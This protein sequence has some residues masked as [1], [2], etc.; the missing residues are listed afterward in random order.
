MKKSGFTLIEVLATLAVSMIA[1]IATVQFGQRWWQQQQE[2]QFFADFQRDWAHL[3][4]MAIT[5]HVTVEVWWNRDQQSFR[6][7]Q[8]KRL[9]KLYLPRPKSLTT[10]FP[11]GNNNWSLMYSGDNFA[12]PQTL[13]FHS[14]HSTDKVQFTWQLG[15]GVLLRKIVDQG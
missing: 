15:T 12:K 13:I 2:A 3:R 8:D 7:G 10:D 14:V 6:F 4:Q 9:T 11:E 1:L 5:D